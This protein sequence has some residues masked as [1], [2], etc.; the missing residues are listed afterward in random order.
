MVFASSAR[1][2]AR[3]DVFETEAGA[4]FTGVGEPG[5][6]ITRLSMVPRAP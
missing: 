2:T 6:K 1:T 4:R 3:S 5:K